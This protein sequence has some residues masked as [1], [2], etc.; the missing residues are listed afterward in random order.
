MNVSKVREGICVASLDAIQ[1]GCLL[2]WRCY[3]F[4][5]YQHS[6][7]LHAMKCCEND[8]FWCCTMLHVG[9]PSACLPKNMRPTLLGPLSLHRRP[10]PPYSFCKECFAPNPYVTGCPDAQHPVLCNCSCLLAQL[11]PLNQ[12]YSANV[13]RWT[14]SPKFFRTLLRD[15]DNGGQNVCFISQSVI[16]CSIGDIWKLWA[17]DRNRFLVT[18]SRKQRF[19]CYSWYMDCLGLPPENVSYFWKISELSWESP[20]SDSCL[21]RVSWTFV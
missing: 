10:L 20:S 19:L 5:L 18:S 12:V 1:F 13:Y 21:K 7:D 8:I 9:E 2:R 15:G 4:Q 16:A 14:T 3:S 11:S 6:R 17:T